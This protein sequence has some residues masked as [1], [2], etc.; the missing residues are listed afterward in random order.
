MV[1]KSKKMESRQSL[2]LDK[3]KKV[4]DPGAQ[5]KYNS[6]QK[7]KKNLA[8]E[9]ISMLLFLMIMMIMIMLVCFDSADNYVAAAYDDDY[10]Y[11]A[12]DDDDMKG[13]I[14]IKECS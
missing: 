5:M 10:D 8:F 11:A 9:F 13:E 4:Y 14:F 1:D 3:K 7:T 12:A 2:A 6:V